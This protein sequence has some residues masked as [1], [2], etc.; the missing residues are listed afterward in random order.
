MVHKVFLFCFA[1]FVFKI[2]LLIDFREGEEDEEGKSIA[3]LNN[4]V[5]YFEIDLILMQFYKTVVLNQWDQK[6]CYYVS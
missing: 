2:V 4:T 3:Y 5:K 1:L 6:G